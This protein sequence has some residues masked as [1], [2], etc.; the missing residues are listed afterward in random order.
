MRALLLIFGILWA[1]TGSA[2]ELLVIASEEVP[3]T[4][5]SIEQLAAIY[6]MKKISWSNGTPVVPVNREA[7][8]DER[9]KFSKA[10]FNLTPQEL[11]AYQDRLRFQGKLPPIVQSSDQAVLGFV[12]SVP[13][14]IGYITASHVPSGVKTLMRLP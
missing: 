7:S 12:R 14:A 1:S 5:I 13:G 4:S 10:V 8:S 6:S 9:A 3:D 11:S 2:G